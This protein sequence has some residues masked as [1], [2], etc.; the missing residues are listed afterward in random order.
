MISK[1]QSTNG[2]LAFPVVWLTVVTLLMPPGTSVA[3]GSKAKPAEPA[4]FK[5]G[6][7]RSVTP[8]TLSGAQVLTTKTARALWQTKTAI[9]IDV[10]PRRSRP[11][12]LPKG[13]IFRIPKRMNIPGSVWLPN[14]GF[15]VIPPNVDAYFRANLHTL[16]GGDKAKPLVI[17]CLENCWMSWNAAKRALRYGYGNIYWYPEGTD[18]WVRQDGPLELSH[19]VPLKTD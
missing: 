12:Q 9:F 6:N 14:V 16:S 10:L 1:R 19:P 2:T 18:G 15:G 17:Y 3:Q 4:G 11:A 13:T 8:E 5:N 7:Y